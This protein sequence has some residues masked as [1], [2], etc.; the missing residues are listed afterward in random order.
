MEFAL[1]KADK[2]TYNQFTGDNYAYLQKNGVQDAFR[3]FMAMISQYRD[4]DILLLKYALAMVS[5]FDTVE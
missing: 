5:A 2:H 4:N 1:Q 3:E